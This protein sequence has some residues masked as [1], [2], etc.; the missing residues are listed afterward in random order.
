MRCKY[1]DEF[2]GICC[3]GDCRSYCADDCIYEKQDECG[4]FQSEYVEEM[5]EAEMKGETK[6][7][8]R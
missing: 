6:Q 4:Y 3:N 5:G 7:C 2:T 1:Y 8:A